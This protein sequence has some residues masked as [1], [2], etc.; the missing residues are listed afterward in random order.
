MGDV[1]YPRGLSNKIINK[2]KQLDTKKILTIY[3]LLHHSR[4][5][6]FIIQIFTLFVTSGVLM[7]IMDRPTFSETLWE[8]RAFGEIDANS[9]HRISHLPKRH[10]I[11]EIPKDSNIKYEIDVESGL[12]FVDRKLPSSMVYPFNY[13]FIPKTRESS[14][15]PVDV[16]IL[17][18]DPLVPMS[19]IQASPIGILLTEDQDGE[20]SKIIAAPVEKV[21]DTYSAFTDLTSI[22]IPILNKL[23][24]FIRHHKDLEKGKYVNIISWENKHL[25]KKVITEAIERYDNNN[26]KITSKSK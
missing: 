26:N 14:G 4:K 22:P 18:D 1:I 13:G 10:V 23:E 19:V 15:D 25:A 6:N 9:L 20:D 24:H 17:G 3:E 7:M 16:F 5:G 12:L 8:W 2:P 21:D 11:I